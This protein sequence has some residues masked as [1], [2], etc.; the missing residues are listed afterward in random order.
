MGKELSD[1]NVNGTKYARVFVYLTLTLLLLFLLDIILGSVS[2]SLREIAGALKDRDDLAGLII[3]SFRLPK[4]FT[5][6][7]AGAALSVSGLLMQTIFRNPLAGP[8][9]LGISSGASLGV[10]VV[11]LGFSSFIPVSAVK[12]SGAWLIAAASWIGAGA[13]MMLIMFISMRIKDILT[14]LIIGIMLS[15]GISAVVSIMQYFSSET[16]LKS[17]VI[18]TMGSLGNVDSGQLRVMALCVLAGLA[19]ALVSSKMLNALLLGE[20]YASTLGTNLTTARVLIFSSTS[21]LAGTVTA[22]CGPIGFIGIAVPHI[23]KFFLRTSEH[24]ILLPASILAGSSIL[25]LSD[26]ISQMPGSD[27]ILP[28]NA[29][30]SLTGIPVIIW[31]I[32]KNREYRF[33]V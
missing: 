28:V 33:S 13:I 11:L 19:L 32:L 8:Y 22:F 31:V 2:L 5:A 18:W 27:K 7:L 6:I 4:A 3:F 17:Y 12:A 26:I 21:L 23:V 15:S 9:V 10:A 1:V 30:T 14:V 24:R 29:I 25:L 20:A 16:M